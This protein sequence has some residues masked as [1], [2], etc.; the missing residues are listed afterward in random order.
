MSK[1][2]IIEPNPNDKDQTRNYFVK[3]ERGYSAYD[4]YV[5]NGGTLAEEEWLD[6][7]LSADNYYSKPETDGKYYTKSDFKVVTGTVAIT[8][9]TGDTTINLPSGFTKDNT[10]VINYTFDA[11][12]GD[13]ITSSSM[14]VAIKTTDQLYVEIVLE[15]DNNDGDTFDVEVVL[16]K[17]SPEISPSV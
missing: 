6:A 14:S 8:G 5:Q 2:T 11:G 12:T 16:M 10:Y 13:K 1:I 17:L 15:N 3:G 7:F 9:D 4:I